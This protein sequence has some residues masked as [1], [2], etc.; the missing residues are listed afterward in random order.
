MAHNTMTHER[1]MPLTLVRFG[2]ITRPWGRKKL[3]GTFLAV[4]STH[5]ATV[6]CCTTY[7]NTKKNAWVISP[8]HCAAAANGRGSVAAVETVL[9]VVSNIVFVQSVHMLNYSLGNIILVQM[10][11]EPC[12]IINI[13][14]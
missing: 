8:A 10:C 3:T 12:F 14:S 11:P 9:V 4:G 5:G 6:W 1:R 2:A 13:I 7:F